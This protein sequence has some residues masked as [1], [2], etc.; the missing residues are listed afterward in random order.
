MNYAQLRKSVLTGLGLAGLFL[1]LLA[2]AKGEEAR[3]TVYSLTC[4]GFHCVAEEMPRKM[5]MED[6]LKL[7]ARIKALNTPPSTKLYEAIVC[8]AEER[9]A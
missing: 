4:V 1:V 9:D 3:A 5:L 2:Q 8:S 6:C 7:Q